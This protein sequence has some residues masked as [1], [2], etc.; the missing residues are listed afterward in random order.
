MVSILLFVPG[1]LRSHCF[2]GIG[3][4]WKTAE[5]VVT[6]HVDYVMATLN[7]D[8]FVVLACLQHLLEQSFLPTFSKVEIWADVGRHFQNGM[9]A[10]YA[11]VC[12]PSAGYH[13]SINF[14]VEK[15]GK[16][17]RDAHFGTATNSFT[18]NR[19]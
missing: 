18:I 17:M 1:E 16:N 5:G 3:V 6:K 13:V 2:L 4:V 11:L 8:A 10:H 7:Q 9:L 12:L 14:F 15:H 19:D